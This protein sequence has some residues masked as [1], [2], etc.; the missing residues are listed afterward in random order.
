[1]REM[2]CRTSPQMF[3]DLAH[4]QRVNCNMCMCNIYV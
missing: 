1:M 4:G 3:Q 2:Q